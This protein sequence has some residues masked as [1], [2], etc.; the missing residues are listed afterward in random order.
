MREIK[1]RGISKR[2]KKYVYGSYWLNPFTNQKSIKT[3]V[4]GGTQ[5][6]D[7]ECEKIGQFTG[8]QDKNGV[9]IYEGDLVNFGNVHNVEV[10][11]DNGCFN[12]FD[13]PLGWDFDSEENPIKTDLKYCEVVGNR[14]EN[15]ELI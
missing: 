15:P 3:L 7:V 11:F 8:L 6:E 2:S 5:L 14:Y 13:E 12:V 4:E 9:D 1:F 10:M